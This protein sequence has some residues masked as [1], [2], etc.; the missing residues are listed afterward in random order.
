MSP[1]TEDGLSLDIERVESLL[2]VKAGWSRDHPEREESTPTP[3][4]IDTD[5]GRRSGRSAQQKTGRLSVPAN[6]PAL[7][8]S[9]STCVIGEPGHCHQSCHPTG[10]IY[11]STSVNTHTLNRTN[12]MAGAILG[13]AGRCD[14]LQGKLMVVDALGLGWCLTGPAHG[15][16][17]NGLAIRYI[18]PV[19]RAI[20][21]I[22]S[23]K[24][25]LHICAI[26]T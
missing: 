9:R 3:T 19:T 21:M 23:H 2:H 18:R 12:D 15:I 22:L 24:P 16:C 10:A 5:A 6:R 20:P 8:G 1:T 14:S 11:L 13:R 7:P 4:K 17:S 26:V 25:A